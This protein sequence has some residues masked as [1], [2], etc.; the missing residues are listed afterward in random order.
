MASKHPVKRDAG[1]RLDRCGYEKRLKGDLSVSK[2]M[3][4]IAA[5]GMRQEAL[6]DERVSCLY[7]RKAAKVPVRCPQFGHAMLLA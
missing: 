6:T 1:K 3:K 7:V 2:T 4:P 5:N